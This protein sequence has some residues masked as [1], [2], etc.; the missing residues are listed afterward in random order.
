MDDFQPMKRGEWGF[1]ALQKPEQIEAQ[2]QKNSDLRDAM[3]DEGDMLT[4]AWL[5]GFHRGKEKRPW[6]DLT[7]DELREFDIDPVEAR[8]LIAKL[9]EKSNAL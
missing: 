7:D 5:D 3:D 9:K 6:V 4:I 2:A 8:K 1:P